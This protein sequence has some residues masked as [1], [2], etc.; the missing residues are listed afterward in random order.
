MKSNIDNAIIQ[1]ILHQSMID[2]IQK[3]VVS[4]VIRRNNKFLLVERAPCDFLGGLITLPGGSV[5]ENENLLQAM[6]REIKE[7][8]GLIITEVTSYLGSFDYASSSEKKVR[9][10]N[11]LVKTKSGNI[12]LDPTE[13]CKYYFLNSSDKKFSTL[14]ISSGTKKILSMAKKK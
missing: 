4:A 8:T 2:G 12:K 11:F 7:E 6:M 10:F 5:Q 9:Q 13:H 14:N 1:Q 3:I